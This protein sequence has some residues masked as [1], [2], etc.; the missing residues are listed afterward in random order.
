[1][2]GHSPHEG[3]TAAVTDLLAA[4]QATSDSDKASLRSYAAGHP[5]TGETLIQAVQLLRDMFTIPAQG[6]TEVPPG[7]APLPSHRTTLPPVDTASMPPNFPALVPTQ[8]EVVPHRHNGNDSDSDI[9]A[10]TTPASAPR[11]F[12]QP[13]A[14]A[15][16]VSRVPTPPTSAA[17]PADTEYTWV[18]VQNGVLISD[19]SDNCC[20][21]V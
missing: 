10:E 9:P 11:T 8:A 4:V 18:P 21:L 6:Q 15:A 17:T 12:A 7:F 5:A 14:P 1:M 16:P 2:P 19:N 13:A 20:G 3:I